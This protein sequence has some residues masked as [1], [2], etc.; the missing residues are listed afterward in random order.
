MFHDSQLVFCLQSFPNLASCENMWHQPSK[1]P[2]KAT[3]QRPKRARFFQTM[4]A[5]VLCV[6]MVWMGIDADNN[7]ALLL[8]E[9]PTIFFVADQ[10]FCAAA[11]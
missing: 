9:A 11:A 3:T 2:S 1:P 6:Y 10:L 4:E 8:T 7:T 5:A